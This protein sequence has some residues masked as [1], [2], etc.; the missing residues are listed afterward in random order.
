MNNST[1]SHRR[2]WETIPW[3]VNG[4]ASEEELRATHEHLRQCAD[5]REALAFEQK[6]RDALSHPRANLSD[7]AQG[8]QRLSARLDDTQM[9]NRHSNTAMAEPVRVPAIG[10]VRWLAA[11]VIVEALALGALV[12]SS[13]INNVERV[14]VGTYRTL[15]QPDTAARVAPTIRVVLSQDMT[16][17]Q[18]HALLKT[19]HLQVVAGPGDSGIWSLAPA[20][21]AATMATEGALRQLRESPQV[22]FAEPISNE[23]DAPAR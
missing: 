3:I 23:A 9:S 2:A 21:N 15:S 22:H 10:P 1:H 14:P 6:L 20:D 18:L 8:W 11:A 7:A 5:C 12:S 13:L 17:G 16:L 19:A 4:S